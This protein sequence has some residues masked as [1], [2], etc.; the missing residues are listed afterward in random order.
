[1]NGRDYGIDSFLR[2]ILPRK[3]SWVAEAIAIGC[4][5]YTCSVVIYW[6]VLIST[7]QRSGW[8]WSPAPN[9]ALWVD[10]LFL[11][12]L[13]PVIESFLFVIVLEVAM[14]ISGIRWVGVVVGILA[15]MAYHWFPDYLASLTGIP[16]YAISAMVY[17]SRQGPRGIAFLVIGSAHSIH[18]LPT[19][20]SRLTLMIQ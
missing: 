8:R 11:L 19:S 12:V 17:L 9:E 18:N 6:F 5:S 4:Y 14:K 7:D 2:Y 20:L 15:A 3:T 1:M 16:L 13:S 10:P